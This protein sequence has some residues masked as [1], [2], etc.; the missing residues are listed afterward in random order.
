MIP[1]YILSHLLEWGSAS[2]TV[3]GT[4][5][6]LRRGSLISLQPLPLLAPNPPLQHL[7]TWPHFLSS[8][9]PPSF[10]Q[11]PGIQEDCFCTLP[12]L[13]GT[14]EEIPTFICFQV[15]DGTILPHPATTG[16]SRSFPHS[17]ISR[18]VVLVSLFRWALTFGDTGHTLQKLLMVFHAVLVHS[19]PLAAPQRA[20]VF[21]CSAHT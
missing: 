17:T 1:A 18:T 4:E 13:R 12:G 19:A 14:K 21:R 2:P 10:T 20:H 7:L 8:S 16:I 15:L 5:N 3:P 6:P 9:A 11:S